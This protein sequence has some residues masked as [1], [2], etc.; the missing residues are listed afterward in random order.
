M[1]HHPIVA[2]GI[3]TSSTQRDAQEARYE[4]TF[5]Q[6]H[7]IHHIISRR[8]HAF[9]SLPYARLYQTVVLS[10]HQSYIFFP[11]ACIKNVDHVPGLIH[12]VLPASLFALIYSAPLPRLRKRVTSIIKPDLRK[13]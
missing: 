3:V 13:N 7:I 8:Q 12:L 5:Q 6:S 1:L 9:D 2:I 4:N 10:D 11:A